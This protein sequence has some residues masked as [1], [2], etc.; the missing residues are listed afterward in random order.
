MSIVVL[1]AVIA[2]RPA[3]EHAQA[4]S[5]SAAEAAAPAN[6]ARVE[7]VAP[8]ADSTARVASDAEFEF[9]PHYVTAPAF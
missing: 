8:A 2:A 4:T 6:D 9:P 3:A 1:G 7:P 5:L